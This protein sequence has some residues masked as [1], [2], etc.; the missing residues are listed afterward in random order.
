MKTQCNSNDSNNSNSNNT[1]KVGKSPTHQ[2]TD[3]FQLSHSPL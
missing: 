1:T 3:C 2:Q